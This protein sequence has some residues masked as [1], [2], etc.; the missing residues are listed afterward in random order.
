MKKIIATFVALM[1]FGL[2]A[3][4]QTIFAN[5]LCVVTFAD[6]KTY[7]S[8]VLGKSGKIVNTKM[9]HSGSLY[10]FK[11]RTVTSSEGFYEAGHELNNIVCYGGRIKDL[12]YV[13]NFVEVTFGD[14]ASYFA[15]VESIGNDGYA[16]KM[17]HSGNKYRFN[18][19]GTVLSSTGAYP[20]GHKTKSVMLLTQRK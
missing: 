13:G 4:A 17:L 7:Y 12:L 9:L 10:S 2:A 6:G 16:T 3:N 11:G 1:L 8:K 15:V 14:G 19:D 20:V 18:G 5:D